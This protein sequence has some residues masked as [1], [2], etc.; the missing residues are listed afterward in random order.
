MRLTDE[1][2]IVSYLFDI[3]LVAGEGMKLLAEDFVLE[4]GLVLLE[5]AL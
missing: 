2:C 5:M 1:F 4:S 3:D